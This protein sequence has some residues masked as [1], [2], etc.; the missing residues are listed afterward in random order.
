[1][2]DAPLG[3]DQDELLEVGRAH[4]RFEASIWTR[5]LEEQGITALSEKKGSWLLG[6]LYLGRVPYAVSV[7][8]KDHGAAL[9]Y[10]K[11]YRFL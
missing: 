4:D 1:V 11:K 7:P 3:S 8:R 10:L 9:A 6:L 5:Q 2:T